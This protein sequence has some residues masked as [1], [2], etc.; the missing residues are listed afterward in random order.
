MEYDSENVQLTTNSSPIYLVKVRVSLMI[1][2]RGLVF[3]FTLLVTVPLI[4][5]ASPLH[6]FIIRERPIPYTLFEAI[7]SEKIMPP[8]EMLIYGFTRDRSNVSTGKTIISPTVLNT[9]PSF[10]DNQVSLQR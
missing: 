9:M 6:Q 7:V 8:P 3:M 1:S 10:R 5:I 2:S 4:G